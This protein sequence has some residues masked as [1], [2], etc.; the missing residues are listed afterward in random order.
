MGDRSVPGRAA[1]KATCCGQDRRSLRY[2]WMSHQVHV[3][4]KTMRKFIGKKKGLKGV[5]FQSSHFYLV[6]LLPLGSDFTN[7]V[8][9]IPHSGMMRHHYN[10]ITILRI[11]IRR[12]IRWYSMHCYITISISPLQM[13]TSGSQEID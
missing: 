5:L 8:S 11:I 7:M 4:R 3:F 6:V 2:P 9:L 12:T 1:Q 13:K 10:T